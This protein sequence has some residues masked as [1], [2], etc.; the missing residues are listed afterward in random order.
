M[1]IAVER[2]VCIKTANSDE[3]LKEL[4]DISKEREQ[5]NKWVIHPTHR[6][7]FRKIIHGTQIFSTH[8]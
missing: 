5:L 6:Q 1:E 3:Y 4:E 2:Q 7:I 8:T